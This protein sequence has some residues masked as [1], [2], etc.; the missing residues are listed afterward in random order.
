M[1]SAGIDCGAKNTKTVIMKDGK[2][3]GKAMVLTGFDQIRA[4]LESFENA[5]RN[6]GLSPDQVERICGTGSG[7]DSVKKAIPRVKELVNDI[8][9]M[10]KAAHYLF[11]CARTVADVGAEEGRAAKL[12]E[13]GNTLDFAVNEKCAAGAGAFIEAMSR[14]LETELTELGPMALQS[15]KEIP[16]NAQCAIFAESEVVGL[17][18]AKTRKADISKAI[19]DAM[20]SRIVSMIR[21]IGVNEDVVMIG[22]VGYNPGFVSAMKKELGI[23]KLLVPEEPEYG[24]AAGAAMVAGEIS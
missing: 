20:A 16:M 6:A 23:E 8:K 18:H 22:G 24:M 12:D 4:I 1:I 2:V 15:D 11:P 7:K 19:H 17:I 10:G 3:I 14:A 9:A 21:R 5:C 13:K